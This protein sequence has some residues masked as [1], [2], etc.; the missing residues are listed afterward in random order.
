MEVFVA[1]GTGG[2][3]VLVG[4][5]VFVLVGMLEVGVASEDTRVSSAAT[6][7][8]DFPFIA[9][10]IAT[11][12]TPATAMTVTTTTAAAWLRGFF[13]GAAASEG[14][15]DLTGLIR[16]CGAGFPPGGACPPLRRSADSPAG[17]GGLAQ[18]RWCRP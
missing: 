15:A 3:G 16:T 18:G 1:V 7:W 6:V 5:G 11:A 10:K 2:T 8:A 17:R 13:A 4:I 9:W 14:A 12:A